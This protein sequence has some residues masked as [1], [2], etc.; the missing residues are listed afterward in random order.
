MSHVNR[1]EMQQFSNEAA[2]VAHLVRCRHGKRDVSCSSQVRDTISFQRLLHLN[3][4]TKKRDGNKVFPRL[5]YWA[6]SVTFK[7][8]LSWKKVGFIDRG[9]GRTAY[10]EGVNQTQLRDQSKLV[11]G[12]ANAHNRS[13]R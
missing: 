9:L 3:N 1:E 7:K 5:I 13:G 12:L 2:S 6:I 10:G 11:P 4:C 8:I